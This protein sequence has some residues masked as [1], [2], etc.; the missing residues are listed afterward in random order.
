MISL[1][2][3]TFLGITNAERKLLEEAFLGGILKC[4]CCT[5]T[6]AAGV[7]LPAQ[8]VKLSYH[9]FFNCFKIFVLFKLEKKPENI[10][11]KEN[12]LLQ[13]L[14]SL[15]TFLHFLHYFFYFGFIKYYRI[16]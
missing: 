15:C 6:L 9:Y 5:S 1:I 13:K 2:Y 12:L 11:F 3:K 14:L 8:R 10:S 7:N 16:D 4:I